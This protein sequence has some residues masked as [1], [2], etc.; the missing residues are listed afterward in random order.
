M[1]L[2][3]EGIMTTQEFVFDLPLYTKASV[4]DNGILDDLCEEIRI[5]GYNPIRGVE[6]SF[7]LK[8]PHDRR[9]SSWRGIYEFRF[10]CLRYGDPLCIFVVVN[11]DKGYIEKVGQ[12]PSVADIHIGQVKKYRKVLGEVY[13]RDFTK[14]IGLAA[15]GVGTGA[16][17]YLRRVF[18]HLVFE[19]GEEMIQSG[20]IDKAQFE[21]SKMDSKLKLLSSNLPEVIMEN[22]SL[23]GVLSAGIHSLSEDVCLQYFS[24]VRTVIE[25]ILDDREYARQLAE[26][27]KAAKRELDAIAGEI[28]KEK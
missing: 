4:L 25:L 18:E 6:T 21:S 5:D 19:I 8:N 12:Y 20:K 23:Y 13:V 2:L 14:A 1:H 11:E 24:A 17:V 26:K 15:N 22:K 27:K 9:F 16:F 28:R 7:I 3:D 10:D